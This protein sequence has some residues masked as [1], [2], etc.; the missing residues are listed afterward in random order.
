MSVMG[1][2]RGYRC[3]KN[4]RMQGRIS[5]GPLDSNLFIL[6][7]LLFEVSEGERSGENKTMSHDYTNA[8]I[9]PICQELPHQVQLNL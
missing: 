6:G 8:W 2:S 4:V 7:L 3:E 1:E 9:L 5:Y